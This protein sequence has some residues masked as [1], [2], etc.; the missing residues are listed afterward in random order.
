[1]KRSF[2]RLGVVACLVTA[3]AACEGPMGPAGA[4]GSGTK[5]VLNATAGTSGSASV[6]L[7]PEAGSLESPPS[8]SCYFSG[9]SGTSWAILAVDSDTD[10]DVEAGLD[11]FGFRGCFLDL[12][13]GNSITVVAEGLAPGWLLR[14]VVLY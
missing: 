7:P 8:I 12:G 3:L 2:V 10:T 4:P 5:L 11:F 9:D 6:N 13:A 1:M 14:V